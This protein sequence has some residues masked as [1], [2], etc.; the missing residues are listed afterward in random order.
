MICLFCN[1]PTDVGGNKRF[2]RECGTVYYYFYRSLVSSFEFPINEHFT[3]F[4]D[5]IRQRAEIY[6][7]ENPV[8]WDE[9]VKC[10]F[11][12]NMS[13]RIAYFDFPSD[14]LTHQNPLI[15]KMNKYLLFM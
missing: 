7:Y 3:F 2:C 11:L 6:H 15:E 10:Y 4:Y 9:E 12:N 1:K 5:V 14:K 8:V 13:H